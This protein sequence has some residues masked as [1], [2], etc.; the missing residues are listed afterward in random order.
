[1]WPCKLKLNEE[2]SKHASLAQQ[3]GF[4]PAFLHTLLKLVKGI[5]KLNTLR[6]KSVIKMM[7]LLLP[8]SDWPGA[9]LLVVSHLLV[10]PFLVLWAGL[11]KSI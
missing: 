4:G 5:A 11:E 6:E 2:K 10:V 9:L 3:N 1:M 7:W 8:V